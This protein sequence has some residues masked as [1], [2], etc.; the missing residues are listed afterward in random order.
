MPR[1]NWNT[2]CLCLLIVGGF[3]AGDCLPTKAGAADNYPERP[4]KIIVPAAAG[5]ITDVETR[6]VAVRLSSALGQPVVVDNRPGANNTIGMAMVAKAPPDGYTLGVGSTSSLAAG[7]ALMANVPYDP[8]RD[9]QPITQTA[10]VASVLLVNSTLN[11][12]TISEF[13]AYAKANSGK[14]TYG[15]NGPGGASHV[16]GELFCKSTGIDVLHVP[17]KSQAPMLM[18]L[19]GNETQM[20]FD[21]PVTAA[22][23]V[24]SGKV[25]ALMVTGSKRVPLFPDVPTAA[26]VGLPDLEIYATGGILA[27]AGTPKEIVNRLHAELVKIL[28]T[29]DMIAHYEETG[30]EPVANAPDEFRDHIAAEL[31]RWK[32]IVKRTGV[33]I[34]Q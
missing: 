7:P 19:L 28:R 27:P 23:H 3:V 30:N 5:G 31:K 15:S 1:I 12:R 34:T 32:Q 24:K 22:Q 13:V 6:R 11:I 20:G 10:R 29:P 17:Y 25:R 9:F 18:A 16:L 21:Y 14:L 33:S 26:Q 4:I 8:I 2:L